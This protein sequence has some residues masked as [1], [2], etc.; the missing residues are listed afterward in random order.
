MRL[1]RTPNGRV[2]LLAGVAA[3]LAAIALCFTLVV[4]TNQAEQYRQQ[5]AENCMAVEQLKGRIRDTFRDAKQHAVANSNLDAAQRAAVL[6]YYA[7]ELARYAA[8]DC[9]SP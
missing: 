4:R 7:R 5:T 8:S 6:S 9:P 3:A 1:V 2:L